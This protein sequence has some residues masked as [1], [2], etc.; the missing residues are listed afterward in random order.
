MISGAEAGVTMRS[1]TI[2]FLGIAV[3]ALSV[4]IEAAMQRTAVVDCAKQQICLYVWPKIP[5]LKGWHTDEDANYD[6]KINTLVPDGF[7]FASTD[8][9]IYAEATNKTEYKKDNPG[10][11]NLDGYIADDEGVFRENNPDVV[12]TEIDPLVTGDGQKLRTVQY[13]KLKEDHRQVVAYG[14]EDDDYIIFVIDARG[15]D[16]L[17]KHLPAYKTLVQSYTTGSE[18]ERHADPNKYTVVVRHQK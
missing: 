17:A 5:A 9:V 14:E 12:I 6:N 8:T 10:T 4:P 2:V 11:T 1:S 18:A 7:T 3:L 16:I 15:A 13:A